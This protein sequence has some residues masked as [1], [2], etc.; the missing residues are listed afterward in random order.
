MI[1]AVKLHAIMKLYGIMNDSLLF[2]L[3]M[4]HLLIT[5]WLQLRITIAKNEITNTAISKDDDIV[6]I[7]FTLNFIDGVSDGWTVVMTTNPKLER[8]MVCMTRVYMYFVLPNDIWISLSIKSRS[9]TYIMLSL[10]IFFFLLLFGCYLVVS[11]F[12]FSSLAKMYI[13]VVKV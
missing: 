5:L 2:Q 9:V 4:A 7:S 11:S 8:I 6:E 3:S 10:R 13:L 1:C 12:V